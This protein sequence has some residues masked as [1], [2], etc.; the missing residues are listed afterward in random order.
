MD[1]LALGIDIGGSG[2]KAGV[3]DLNRAEML[4]E[5]VRIP[6]PQPATPEA[7]APV[8]A[9]LISAHDWTGPVGCAFPGTVQNGALIGSAANLDP[10]WIGVD[11]AELF[12]TST[13]PV[14]MINDADA[15]GLAEIRLCDNT[16]GLIVMITIGTGLG[17]ALFY[18]G[19]L[20][21]NSELG[22][23]EIDG[24][25]AEDRASSRAKKADDL[26]MD[27]WA[28]ERF[29]VYLAK[30]EEL[31]SPDR[32]IIGGGI[33]KHFAE[34]G[35]LLETRAVLEPAHLRNQAGIVGAAMAAR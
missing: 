21:P 18:N 20:V 22:H 26:P 35:P 1:G 12:S 28:T 4:D 33:S 14:T 30:I 29:Q 24:F 6:T 9:E 23:I 7:M 2:M 8:V 5:R 15:A 32:F 27:V 10:T 16:D 13:T 19:V 25:I 17:T 34:F 11:A 31:L 3:V